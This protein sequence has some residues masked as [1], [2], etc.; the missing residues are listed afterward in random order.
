MPNF[1]IYFCGDSLELVEFAFE[2]LPGLAF[3][4]ELLGEVDDGRFGGL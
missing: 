4:L 2:F 3:L 1:L